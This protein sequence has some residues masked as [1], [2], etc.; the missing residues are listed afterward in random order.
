MSV[1]S[2]TRFTVP[3]ASD[4]SA[5]SQGMLMPKLS[6][7]FR[8]SFEQFGVSQPVTELTKQVMDVT[9]PTVQFQDIVVD[10]YNSKIKLLGKP[11]WQDI[12]V[13]LRDDAAGNVSRLVG[14]QLQKQY[15]FMEQASAAAGIDYKFITRIEMLDGGN[16]VSTPNVLETWEIYGCYVSQVNYGEVNY[17]SGTDLVKI[18]MTIKYDNAVQT[19]DGSGVGGYV[20]RLNGE[21]ATG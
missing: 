21:T 13:N 12:T 11:E 4:Q 14:E 3:L 15:D 7:R 5:S 17:A 1:A 20:G 2:L 8:V 10:V 16:G 19:P 6:Y 9:R 18:A